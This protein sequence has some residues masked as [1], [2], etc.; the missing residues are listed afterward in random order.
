VMRVILTVCGGLAILG[1]AGWVLSAAQVPNGSP[2]FLLIFVVFMIPPVGGLWMVYV[3]IR[4]EANPWPMILLA[5][6]P[7]SFV[8]YYFDRYR[9]VKRAAPGS[10]P[11]V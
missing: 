6:V 3:S 9:L 7:Y 2:M 10:R 5:L 8:W 1:L 11:T 4:Y